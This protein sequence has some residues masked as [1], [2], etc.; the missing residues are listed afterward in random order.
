MQAARQ[1]SLDAF[2]LAWGAVQFSAESRLLE[3]LAMIYNTPQLFFL[4]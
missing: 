4:K 1:L 2:S 3:A